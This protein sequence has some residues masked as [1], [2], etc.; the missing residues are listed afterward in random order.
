MALREV[1]EPAPIGNADAEE[2]DAAWVTNGPWEPSPEAM[3]AYK[4]REVELAVGNVQA[5]CRYMGLLPGGYTRKVC[6]LVRTGRGSQWTEYLA[7]RR[8]DYPDDYLA[9]LTT[10]GAAWSLVV[11]P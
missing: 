5:M 10:M 8:D 6:R 7:K 1:P 3:A 11:K 2:D 4:A 9:S